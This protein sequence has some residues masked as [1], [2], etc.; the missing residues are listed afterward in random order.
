M[1]M[2]KSVK[3]ILAGWY[4]T[5]SEKSPNV[6]WPR[7]YNSPPTIRGFLPEGWLSNIFA[8]DDDFDMW[9]SLAIP[10]DVDGFHRIRTFQN[11]KMN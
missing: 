2:L 8:P 10:P 7:F 6:V 4:A 11:S 1:W 9:C 3:P 5:W